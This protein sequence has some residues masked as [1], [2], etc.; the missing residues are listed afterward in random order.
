MR[1]LRV[2]VYTFEVGSCG[3]RSREKDRFADAADSCRQKDG[4]QRVDEGS[5]SESTCP[6]CSV[7]E[8]HLFQAY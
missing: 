8:M 4:K 1:E 7:S 5:R 6:T 2:H 3:C